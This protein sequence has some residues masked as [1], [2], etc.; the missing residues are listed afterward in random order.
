MFSYQFILISINTGFEWNVKW[1]FKFFQ[2]LVFEII[3][4][5]L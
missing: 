4:H 2:V 1:N 5:T 3:K